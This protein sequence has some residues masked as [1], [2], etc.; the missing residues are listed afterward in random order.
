[1]K[2]AMGY[3]HLIQLLWLLHFTNA[4]VIFVLLSQRVQHIITGNIPANNTWDVL[5]IFH[6]V[7]TMVLD[8]S[9]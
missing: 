6:L 8:C 7:V 3:I 4:P 9:T 5:F 2:F 1:M